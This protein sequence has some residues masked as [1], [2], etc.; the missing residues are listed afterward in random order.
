VGPGP[1][2]AHLDNARGFVEAI[3]PAPEG[4]LLDLGSGGGIPGLALAAGWPST[5]WLFVDANRRSIDFLQ[6]AVAELGITDRVSVVEG[7]AEDLGHDP[8]FRG[9]V[10]MVVARSFGSPPVTAECAAGFL[11]RGGRLVVSEPPDQRSERWS[12]PGLTT[13]GQR[14]LGITATESGHHFALIEQVNAAPDRFPRRTGVP[15]RR[16]LF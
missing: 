9:Q 4:L 2:E 13:L 5:A 1:V 8:Q 15:S 14:L 11:M 7:R 10:S 6:E 3:G 16:P 12:A